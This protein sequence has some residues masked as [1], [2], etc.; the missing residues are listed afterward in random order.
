MEPTFFLFWKKVET[1]LEFLTHSNKIPK[2][3]C[4]SAIFSK[5]INVIYNQTMHVCPGF[6]WDSINF[7]PSSWCSAVFGLESENSANW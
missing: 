7:L 4:S 3:Y 6:G 5:Y 1:G 2:N